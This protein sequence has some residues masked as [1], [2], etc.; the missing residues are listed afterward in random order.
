MHRAPPEELDGNVLLWRLMSIPSRLPHDSSHHMDA[1]TPRPC[2]QAVQQQMGKVITLVQLEQYN[3]AR[4]QLREGSA[5][6]LRKD[7]RD[8]Q[9]LYPGVTS[10]VCSALA[11]APQAP[12]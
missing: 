2:L 11:H 8:A 10:E 7:L 6:S 9:D 1:G 12:T 4:L 3:A 5:S